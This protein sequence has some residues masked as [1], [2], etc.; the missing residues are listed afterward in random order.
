MHMHVK[1]SFPRVISGS[2]F[3]MDLFEHSGRIFVH[4]SCKVCV[5]SHKE[6]ISRPKSGLKSIFVPVFMSCVC[7]GQSMFWFFVH[8]FISVSTLVSCI[9]CMH[10][11]VHLY[12]IFSH[13]FK[14]NICPFVT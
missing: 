9:A 3:E 12:A 8:V 11:Y 13:L 6:D 10:V 5:A 4:I 1:F 14:K 7:P 2:K